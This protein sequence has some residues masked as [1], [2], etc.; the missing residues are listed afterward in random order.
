MFCSFGAKPIIV[1]LYCR[2]EELIRDDH[3]WE[4]LIRHFPDIPGC[5]N[6]FR[7]KTKRI[8]TSCGFGVLHYE[9]VSQRETLEKWTMDRGDQ[10]I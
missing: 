3:E 8:Q 9:F 1:R 10:G 5:R 6:I 4:Q 2:A 7:C